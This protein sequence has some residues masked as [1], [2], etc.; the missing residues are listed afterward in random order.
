MNW[1]VV[2]FHICSCL[3]W[4][5]YGP[6][7]LKLESPAYKLR[8]SWIVE[9]VIDLGEFLFPHPQSL[10]SPP[11]F[12]KVCLC[13]FG[14][15]VCTVWPGC[16]WPIDGLIGLYR[17]FASYSINRLVVSLESINIIIHSIL[18]CITHFSLS[19]KFLSF[20]YLPVG[21]FILF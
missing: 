18:I 2:R 20:V 15:L 3:S 4:S 8:D 10:S 5:G 12:S 6:A 1:K 21:F 9:L 11:K 13:V 19:T 7:H 17:G 16:F 14:D